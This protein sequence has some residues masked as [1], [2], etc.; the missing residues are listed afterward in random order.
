[1][2]SQILLSSIIHK[3]YIPFKHTLKYEVPSL[4]INLDNLDQLSKNNKLLNNFLI[5]L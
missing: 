4:F 2:I 3:R 1:M 5:A